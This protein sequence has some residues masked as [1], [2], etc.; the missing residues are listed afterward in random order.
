MCFRGSNAD[1]GLQQDRFGQIDMALNTTIRISEFAKLSEP[2]QVE[3]MR[4]FARA[5]LAPLN[6]DLSELNQRI[7]SYECR[8]EMSSE[9]MLMEYRA[10]KLRETADICHWNILLNLRNQLGT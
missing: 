7:A 2:E 6:G 9:T 1:N 4:N 8:Y 10:G 3:E 5:R